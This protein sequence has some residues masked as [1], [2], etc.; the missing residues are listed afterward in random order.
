MGL[1]FRVLV[2]RVRVWTLRGSFQ[3]SFGSRRSRVEG[4]I[5]VHVGVSENRGP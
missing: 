5:G 4:L 3:G 2:Y 1:G